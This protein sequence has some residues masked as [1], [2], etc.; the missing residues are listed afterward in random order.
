MN[1]GCDELLPAVVLADSEDAVTVAPVS[2][3]VELATEWD[4]L[5]PVRVLGYEAITEVWNYGSILAEQLEEVLAELDPQTIEDL[6]SLARAAVTGGDPP[7][8]VRVG[9]PVLDDADPRLLFQDAEA[10][11]CRHFWEPA[12]A[13]AG[14]LTLGQ[15]VAHRRSELVV[16]VDELE[17][18]V[19]P[20]GLARLERDELDVRRS[21]PPGSLAALMRRLHIG[22]SRRLGRIAVYTLETQRTAPGGL[23]LAR[24]SDLPGSAG[25]DVPAV[26]EY[27]DA[28]LQDLGGR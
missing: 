22:A 10:E 25:G 16:P 7:A 20:G 8:D 24:G 19:G 6:Q 12:L 13:L 18:L 21:L 11:R 27:V 5:V 14:A 1:A 3:R 28:F 17:A 15:L 23:A 2:D 4:L 9:P 26:H